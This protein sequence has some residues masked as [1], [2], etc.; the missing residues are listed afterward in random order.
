MLRI[1]DYIA[2][3]EVAKTEKA[4]PLMHSCECFDS[5]LIIESG[6][7]KVSNCKVLKEHK[8][9]Y[10]FYGKPAYPVGEKIPE[11]R[12]D[13]DYCPVCFIMNPNAVKIYRVFPF[14]T[15]AFDAGRYSGFLHRNMK[16]EDFELENSLGMI[17]KYISVCFENN[18]KYIMGETK[19][20]GSGYSLT[21]DALI[22]LLNANS[23]SA[24]D[25]RSRTIEVV[26]DEDVYLNSA[27]EYIIMPENLLREDSIKDYLDKNHVMFGTY[28]VRKLTAP[29]YYNG[30]VFDMA[31]EYLQT[32]EARTGA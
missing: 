24:F 32:K 27:I 30:T 10:F 29:S 9:L 19:I 4:L 11:N 3:Q 18:E 31:M 28:K 14:D 1:S 17:Q 20:T 22:R 16:L 21:I 23:T 6:K 2:Q 15:G 5:Q 26:T 8:V 7:L 12:E 25:E 13:I